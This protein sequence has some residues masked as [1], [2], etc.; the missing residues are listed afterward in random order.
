MATALCYI[1]S[2]NCFNTATMKKS[3]PRVTIS[4][5]PIQSSKHKRTSRWRLFKSQSKKQSVVPKPTVN[6]IDDEKVHKLCKLFTAKYNMTHGQALSVIN[7]KDGQ[8]ITRI[9]SRWRISPIEALEL[10]DT[11]DSTQSSSDKSPRQSRKRSNKISSS[12]KAI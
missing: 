8:T 12:R 1:S 3:L 10:L 7:H 2:R 5:E 4:E 11:F 9:A 6:V